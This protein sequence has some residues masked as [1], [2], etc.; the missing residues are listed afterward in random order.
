MKHITSTFAPQ[1]FGNDC[2]QKWLPEKKK[3]KHW[4]PD[5]MTNNKWKSEARNDELFV[6]SFVPDNSQWFGVFPWSIVFLDFT[7][8][9]ELVDKTWEH[10]PTKKHQKNTRKNDQTL[11]AKFNSKLQ[12]FTR[13]RR[14]C[15][16]LPRHSNDL[17]PVPAEATP[18]QTKPIPFMYY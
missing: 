7:I 4:H 3:K 9:K 16:V 11:R 5:L 6:G 13:A 12:L 15:N 14:N 1:I 17:R 2:G 18:N 10:F 8:G